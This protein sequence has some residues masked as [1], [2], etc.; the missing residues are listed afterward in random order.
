MIKTSVLLTHPKVILAAK[1]SSLAGL[2][3]V[4]CLALLL[5]IFHLSLA[6]RIYP[7]V[8]AGTIDLSFKNKIEAAEI[9]FKKSKIF[10]A[11][12]VNIENEKDSPAYNDLNIKFDLAKTIE[13]AYAAGRSGNIFEQLFAP[14]KNLIWPQKISL[15][16]E[17]DETK[18]AEFL[19][20]FNEKY[21]VA[22]VNSGLKI[23]GE[24]VEVITAQSG[25]K[26]NEGKLRHDILAALKNL[27]S[28]TI[29]LEINEDK[30]EILEADVT[31]AKSAAEKFIAAN[32]KLIW[33][34]GAYDANASERANWL[35]FKEA[36]TKELPTAT[37][38][39][40]TQALGF[41]AAAQAAPDPEKTILV[42]AAN[43]ESLKNFLETLRPQTDVAAQNGWIAITDNG[44]IQTQGEVVGKSL[45][46]DKTI[47]A[48][49][50][51]LGGAAEVSLAIDDVQPIISTANLT[52]QGITTLLGRGESDFSG[53]SW[54][55]ITNIT[56]GAAKFNGIFLDNGAEFSF[57]SYLGAVDA[58]GGYVPELV[59]RENSLVP[60][61]GGGLCQ[62]ATTAFRMALLAGVPITER[63]E[64]AFRVGYY[65][66]PFGPGVDATIYPP[67]P[68]LK[69]K[70]DTGGKIFIQ[71]YASGTRLVFEMFGPATG[72]KVT[73]EG[74]YQYNV[75]SDGSMDTNFIRYITY[76]DGKVT[77]DEYRSHFN[78]PSN[79]PRSLP[80]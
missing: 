13:D 44:A 40:Q 42:L 59:I 64:H 61:Y 67:S 57:N 24:K 15:S 56:I 69:F 48:V 11:E 25:K 68:D 76:A 80:N 50:K 18:L 39:P 53:S 54:S 10:L 31:S 6:E 33:A 21:N 38:V 43:K 58:S 36:K 27:T 78:P 62:V 2:A 79:Y 35:D 51:A 4:V 1:L 17:I 34:G 47:E 77:K 16:F 20:T 73:Y 37:A 75:K 7:R 60:E 49:E 12:Q 55:R 26:L 46:I 22:K 72:R 14:I 52:G 74:P 9:L 28:K 30:P 63:T 66:W 5:G 32:F 19:Q 71:T 45:N 8:S 23:V 65:D 29:A 3:V 70:N 41:V